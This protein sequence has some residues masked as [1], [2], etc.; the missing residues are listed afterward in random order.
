[1]DPISIIGVLFGVTIVLA[2]AVMEGV[3]LDALI[4]PTALMIIGG[5]TLG[6]TLAC[7]SLDEMKSFLSGLREIVKKQEMTVEDVYRTLGD[8]A[9][10]ARREG[11][12]ALENKVES[13]QHPLL[14]RGVRLMIDG[15]DP[16]LLK[17]MMLTD[18]LMREEKLKVHASIMQTAGGF[19]P[20]MGIIGTVLGL[21]HVLGNLSNPDDLGPAIA[22]AFLATLYGIGFA[23][24]VLLP[25]GK[26][27]QYVAKELTHLGSMITEGVLSIQA[28]DNP[29]LVQEK[30]LSFID[31]EKW[32]ELL[33][34]KTSGAKEGAAA[35]TATA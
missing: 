22:V 5:G 20:C 28:G 34:E 25:L 7:Y 3:H 23:N 15:T 30:L 12:L 1:M 2:A 6:A 31:H 11:V 13:L 18:L 21:F 14:K 35:K 17:D 33:G 26:K 29:R 19:A 27:L 10:V 9:L 4:A 8:V 16:A 32:D 24:L